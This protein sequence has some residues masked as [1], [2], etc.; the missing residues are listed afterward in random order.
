MCPQSAPSDTSG[1]WLFPEGFV[2]GW[3]QRPAPIVGKEGVLFCGNWGLTGRAVGFW[4]S[5]VDRYGRRSR[6]EGDVDVLEDVTGGDGDHAVGFDEV[7]AAFAGLLAAEAVDK[8]EGRAEDAGADGEAGAVSLPGV[9]VVLIVKD[10]L[11]VLEH[12]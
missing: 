8:A 12:S 1:K 6:L 10:L 9:G 5:A 3:L 4:L 2:T 11:F 7:V